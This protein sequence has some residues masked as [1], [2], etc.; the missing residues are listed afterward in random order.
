MNFFHQPLPFTEM[1]AM[2]ELTSDSADYCFVKQEEVC[3]VYSPNSA[4]IQI[5]LSDATGAF[6]VGWFNPRLGWA[7]VCG[8][9]RTVSRG[10]EGISIG[11]APEV[12]GKD[13]VAV[14]SAQSIGRP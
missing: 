13:W 5:D 1:S 6:D 8:T 7:P 2:G 12:D 4:P 3:C 9:V 14:D 11:A 10:A